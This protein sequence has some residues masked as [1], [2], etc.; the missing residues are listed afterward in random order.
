MSTVVNTYIAPMDYSYS[1][2]SN[3]AGAPLPR[4]PRRPSASSN[5]RRSPPTPPRPEAKSA[6]PD[7]ASSSS[8]GSDS[9][10]V[11]IQP[12]QKRVRAPRVH[13]LRSPEEST[14]TPAVL[15]AKA[16]QAQKGVAFP[17]SSDGPS[18]DETTPRAS[19]A[20]RHNLHIVL[21]TLRP[22]LPAASS[23]TLGTPRVDG[24][25]IVS[26][27]QPGD[28]SVSRDKTGRPLKSSLKSRRPAVR[29]DL[30]V[31]T[32]HPIT[33]SE[34]ATP[35]TS[36]SVHFDA[37]LEHV[38]LFLA[39]QKPLAI[40]REGSPTDTS[41]SE[42]DFPGSIYGKKGK[43]ES[44]LTMRVT[45]M[46]VVPRADA[47]LAL[48]GLTLDAD[49][50]Q[51]VGRIRVRNIAFEKWV[52]VRFTVD[53]WQT[54]SEVTAK[55]LDS[56]PGGVF[57]RFSFTIRLGDMLARI[58]EKK[59][60]FAI[61][62]NVLGREVWDNNAGANYHVV[63]SKLA[64]PRP[65]TPSETPLGSL[66][67]KLED[68]AKGSSGSETVGAF[69][70]KAAPFT[71]GA[72]TSLSSRALA[73]LDPARGGGH[74]HEARAHPHVHVPEPHVRPARQDP[75]LDDAAPATPARNQA[76]ARGSPRALESSPFER[77]PVP[78]PAFADE[79]ALEDTP[80]AGMARRRNHARG[81][82]D[83]GLAPSGSAVKMTPP[84]S[85]GEALPP[86][87][88]RGLWVPPPP[89]DSAESTPSVSSD[90]NCSSASSS[91]TEELGFGFG[92]QSPVGPSDS[93]SSFL[94]KYCY[95]T[96]G[97]ESM[98]D[99]LG[100]D[101]IQRSHSASSVE[102][103][104]SMSPARATCSRPG[105]R[106]RARA[107]PTTSWACAAGRRRRRRARPCPASPSRRD[108]PIAA[109]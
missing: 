96:G 55:Y 35:S 76:L 56:I 7:E 107:A 106:R 19:S 105:R 93:Y 51:L 73:A 32:G 23:S 26:A 57:D 20:S 53:D 64:R 10:F 101:P 47:D 61:R 46:P 34:P 83:L 59:M 43:D 85:P 91:P 18:H 58:E 49:N 95:Y 72:S 100:Q 4:I 92:A 27:P 6:N 44:T 80:V 75:S 78:V 30:S 1:R 88:T 37:K 81:Y 31:V 52:A 97:S 33:K 108:A 42:S 104:L 39:E 109:A 24:P 13:P 90:S 2:H 68:V 60:F 79:E 22:K 25:R 102:E 98:L 54:T 48:E 14:P 94:D 36:K 8:S 82:F 66:K 12:R 65:A 69:M 86:T 3:L 77:S 11:H 62:Y 63:F 38:K 87:P 74:A 9:N 103:L 45:N 99:A 89:V 16:Q 71:L 29:G 70:A 41:A 17:V 28:A 50:A 15:H 21:D 5:P 84:T 67:T 40:S